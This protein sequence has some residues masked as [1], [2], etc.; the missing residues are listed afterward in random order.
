ME[1]VAAYLAGV[2]TVLVILN[3][4]YV[5]SRLRRGRQPERSGIRRAA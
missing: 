2:L 5:L 3:G 4:W 1:I